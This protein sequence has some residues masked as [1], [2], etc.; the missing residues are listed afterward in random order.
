[1]SAPPIGV[2]PGVMPNGVAPT[3]TIGVAPG[4]SATPAGVSSHRERCFLPAGVAPTAG[5]SPG[6]QPGV[7]PPSAY[8]QGPAFHVSKLHSNRASQLARLSDNSHLLTPR[9]LLRA[10]RWR[11]PASNSPDAQ[12]SAAPPSA[13]MH[14]DT[15]TSCVIPQLA[16]RCTNTLSSH[17]LVQLPVSASSLPHGTDRYLIALISAPPAG[18]GRSAFTA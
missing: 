17:T 10:R 14:F 3:P 6:A 13:C 16:E 8:A 4:A 7:A 15:N 12:P 2:I 11:T 5:V 1:M 18:R 9:A